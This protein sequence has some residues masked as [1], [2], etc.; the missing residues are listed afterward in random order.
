M[1]KCFDLLDHGGVWISFCEKGSVRRGLQK[2]GFDV[3]R[4][5]GPPGKRE[6]LRAVK[7]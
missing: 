7:P 1:K 6:I 4:L 5:S 3:E 2:V